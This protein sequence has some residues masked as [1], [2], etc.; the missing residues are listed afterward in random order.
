MDRDIAKWVGACLPCAARK[1]RRR[2]GTTKPGVLS[3]Q[4]PWDVCAIDIVGPLYESS[5]GHKYILTIMDCFSKFPIA[6]P[7]K[8][9]GAE[10]VA[11]VIFERVI[12]HHSCPKVLLSDNASNFC[13]E[14]MEA[15]TKLFNIRH[16]RTVAYTPQLNSYLE[17]FHGWMMATV[18]AL[19]N[20]LKSD[21]HKWL[22]VALYVY[23]TSTHASTGYSPLEILTGRPPRS[24]MD[25]AFP[26]PR[27]NLAET[28]YMRELEQNIS[29]IYL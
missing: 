16:I 6:V 4:F 18:T 10:E 5:E 3:T 20:S 26:V 12:A 27:P 15:L 25:L 8:T 9:T 2:M 28:D 19:T 17:R 7:L 14:V 22:P 23:R 21:W 1:T 24:D 11:R 29:R 13:G